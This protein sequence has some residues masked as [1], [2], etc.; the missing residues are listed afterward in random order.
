MCFCAQGEC[1]TGVD[2]SGPPVLK[3]EPFVQAARVRIHLAFQHLHLCLKNPGQQK[4]HWNL[5]SAMVP[6]GLRHPALL[7]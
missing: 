5:T 1:L 7:E 6:K 2:A 4:P 3:E